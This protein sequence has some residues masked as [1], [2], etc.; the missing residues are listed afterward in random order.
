MFIHNT[1][2]P[3]TPRPNTFCWPFCFCSCIITL[4]PNI[5][6]KNVFQTHTEGG[7]ACVPTGKSAP[8]ALLRHRGISPLQPSSC[9]KDRSTTQPTQQSSV[10]LVPQLPRVTHRTSPYWG[11]AYQVRSWASSGNTHFPPYCPPTCHLEPRFTARLS[12][13]CL[14][15]SPVSSPTEPWA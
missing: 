10:L 5:T 1:Q 9:R 12:F 3:T 14:A 15:Q 4:A 2:T 7:L 11:T 13:A 6:G 8:P